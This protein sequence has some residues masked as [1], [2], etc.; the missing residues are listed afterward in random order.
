MLGE[1]PRAPAPEA[2]AGLQ[3]LLVALCPL[4]AELGAGRTHRPQESTASGRYG[5]ALPARPALPG[6]LGW[7]CC[8]GTKCSCTRAQ[9]ITPQPTLSL[10]TQQPEGLSIHPS[11]LSRQVQCLQAAG[12]SCETVNSF[13]PFPKGKCTDA[14]VTGRAP[15]QPRPGLLA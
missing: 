13:L 14:V 12:G 10:C 2:G 11:S 9:G 4:P 3:V 7:L 6:D 5:C 1:A 15:V 8:A